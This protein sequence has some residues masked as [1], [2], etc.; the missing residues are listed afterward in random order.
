MRI[1]TLALSITIASL[2]VRAAAQNLDQIAA[3]KC[4]VTKSKLRNSFIPPI[5][6]DTLVYETWQD[7]LSELKF[8]RTARPEQ[9]PYIP[10]RTSLER[11]DHSGLRNENLRTYVGIYESLAQQIRQE[12]LLEVRV[13]DGNITLSYKDRLRSLPDGEFKVTGS[14]QMS[15]V[16]I[17]QN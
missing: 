2:P 5:V 16:A 12:T 3:L 1:L 15:C 8:E 9:N 13:A 11:V 10:L 17:A 4:T 14:L 6:G 7:N